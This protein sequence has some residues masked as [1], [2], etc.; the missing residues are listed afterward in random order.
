MRRACQGQHRGRLSCCVPSLSDYVAGKPPP[1]FCIFVSWR[2][3]PRNY[4]AGG[5]ACPPRRGHA[6]LSKRHGRSPKPIGDGSD[7][8]NGLAST[9]ARLGTRQK[10]PRTGLGGFAHLSRLGLNRVTCAFD[11]RAQQTHLPRRPKDVLPPPKRVPNLQSVD[12]SRRFVSRKSRRYP[13]PNGKAA[14]RFGG[15]ASR[16]RR[17]CKQEPRSENRGASETPAA[18]VSEEAASPVLPRSLRTR[19]LPSPCPLPSPSAHQ[20]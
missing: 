18:N 11:C 1:R 8:K 14:M 4:A 3:L 13:V 12:T 9:N 10:Q 5:T 6:Q 16:G 20:T 15:A 2:K 17:R 7:A 19:S